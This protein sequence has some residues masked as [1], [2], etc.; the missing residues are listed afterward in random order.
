[1]TSIPECKSAQVS[2]PAVA[3]V[4][5]FQNK[6]GNICSL[7]AGPKRIAGAGILSLFLICLIIHSKKQ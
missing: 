3:V 5:Q 6:T 7:I 4:V 2:L 1:V